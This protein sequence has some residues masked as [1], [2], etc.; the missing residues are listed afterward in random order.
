MGPEYPPDNKQELL[1]AQGCLDESPLGGEEYAH[2]SDGVVSALEENSR[3]RGLVVKLTDL[4]LR[5]V[6][7]R[8]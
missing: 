6:A 7:D 2:D 5:G 8:R 3:L 4:I 1:D